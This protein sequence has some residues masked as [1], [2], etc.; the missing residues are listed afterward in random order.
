M[1]I[2]EEWNPLEPLESDGLAVIDPIV[3][4]PVAFGDGSLDAPVD[5][6]HDSPPW[7]VRSVLDGAAREEPDDW[8][9]LAAC[10]SVPGATAVFFSEEL[11]DIVEAKGICAGCP[12]IAPCLE[13]AIARAEPC[14]VWGGQL[15]SNGQVLTQKRRRGRPPKVARPEDQLPMVPVPAHLQRLIA[16]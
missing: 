15:F 2:T 9:D 3:T 1:T 6:D 12:V 7:A 13:G 16:S 8:E 14:G 5:T 11:A 4:G 10:R